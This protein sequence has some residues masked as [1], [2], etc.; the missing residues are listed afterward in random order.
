[1]IRPWKLLSLCV[2]G[3]ALAGCVG[4]IAGDDSKPAAG[5]SGAPAATAGAP[6]TSP[7]DPL[8]PGAA[9]DIQAVMAKPEN[10]CVNGG[11]HGPLYQG[12]LD[13]AS[14]WPGSAAP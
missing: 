6:G 2:C 12:G 11:C 7:L 8:D 4:S 5:S 13:L 3:P 10:G 14:P 9:C 1:M